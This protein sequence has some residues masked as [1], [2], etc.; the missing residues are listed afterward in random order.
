MI[1]SLF[2]TSSFFSYLLSIAIL[3]AVVFIKGETR[4]N[5]FGFETEQSIAL[6]LLSCCMLAVD[7]AV[8]KHYWA[9]QANFHLLLFPLFVF[10]LPISSWHNWMLMFLFFFWIAFSYLVAINQSGGTITKVFNAFFFF[11]M[12][13]LFFPQ[14]VI[15]LP[16]LWLIILIKGV[17]SLQS[18]F[19]STLPIVALLLLEVV[20]VYF[21]PNRAIFPAVDFSTIVFSRPWEPLFRS[22]L[23]R[24]ILVVLFLVALF[25]HYFDMGTKSA[26]YGTGMIAMFVTTAAGILFGLA[27]QSQSYFAWIFFLMPLTA[28][29]THVFEEIKRTWLRELF[30]LGIIAL[31]LIGKQGLLG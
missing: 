5:F 14:G 28:L 22:N 26:S 12:G 19:V 15:L 18:F 16:L 17:L 29:A 25:K 31:L 6:L 13:C 23:W 8:K 27:F 10:A 24:I 11:F 3:A 1:A 21:F 7:W 30:F 2:K 4:Q 20:I 9:K